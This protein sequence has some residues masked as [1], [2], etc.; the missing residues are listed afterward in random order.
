MSA[1]GVFDDRIAR[2]Y[3]EDSAGMF[4]PEVLGPTVDFLAELADGRRALEFAI[5][6]G[7]VGL[8]LCARGVDVSGIELSGAM[9]SRSGITSR[10][11]RSTKPGS[12]ICRQRSPSS[13]NICSILQ[14]A[15]D[16]YQLR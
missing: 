8:P 1:D 9:E 12:G 5:G 16:E 7:R 11:G 13:S 14:P 4:A 15:S 2:T 6:T 10:T 3:D